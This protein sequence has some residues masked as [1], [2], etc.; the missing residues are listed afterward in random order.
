[1]NDIKLSENLEFNN[2]ISLKLKGTQQ[3]VL[4][5][6]QNLKKDLEKEN[7]SFYPQITVNYSTAKQDNLSLIES[8]IFIISDS[9]A[10]EKVKDKYTVRDKVVWEKVVKLNFKGSPKDFTCATKNF[11]NY[12]KNNDVKINPGLYIYLPKEI[13]TFDANEEIETTIFSAIK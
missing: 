8:E 5:A 4:L 3:E 9:R 6:I 2:V 13:S 7:I 10:T 12:I 1:M 11:G